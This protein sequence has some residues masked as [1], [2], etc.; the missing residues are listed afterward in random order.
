MA[1][2]DSVAVSVGLLVVLLGMSAFFSSTEIAVFS[3]S[4]EWLTDRVASGDDRASVLADLRADPHRLLVTLLVG[5]NVAISSIL[6]VLL[7][8]RLP[9]SLAVVATTVLAS[10]VVLVCGEILRK[11][12]GLGNAEEWALRTARPVRAVERVL[13]PVVTVFDVVTR[14]VGAAVGGDTDIEEPY[15]DAPASE[16]AK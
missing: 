2:L 15:T 6:A 10:T 9:E 12:Y 7:A 8:A 13:W 3:L 16:G 1:L 5:N 14:R 4:P 11:A